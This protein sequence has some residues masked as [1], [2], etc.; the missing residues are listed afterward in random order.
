MRGARPVG[1]DAFVRAAEARVLVVQA[2]LDELREGL[3]VL[4]CLMNL[5]VFS[6]APWSRGSRRR[7]MV[8]I[9]QVL[10]PSCGL[11]RCWLLKHQR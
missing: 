11:L 8:L 9:G 3:N 10:N 5:T 7:E 2:L 6:L 1:L 4:G